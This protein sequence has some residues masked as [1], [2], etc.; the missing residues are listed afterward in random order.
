MY[1]GDQTRMLRVTR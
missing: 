1:L